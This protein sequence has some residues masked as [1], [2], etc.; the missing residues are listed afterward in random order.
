MG[1]FSLVFN[2]DITIFEQSKSNL[3]YIYNT[4]KEE[5]PEERPNKKR[6]S[7]FAG[8]SKIDGTKDLKC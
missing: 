7:V 8:Q 4:E 2:R 3:R 5:K 1:G 6:N